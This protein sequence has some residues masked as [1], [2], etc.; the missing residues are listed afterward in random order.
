MNICIYYNPAVGVRTYLYVCAYVFMKVLRS[1]RPLL[2]R[3]TLYINLLKY[4]SHTCLIHACLFVCGERGAR[5]HL[6][7]NLAARDKTSTSTRIQQRCRYWRPGAGAVLSGS[8]RVD[9]IDR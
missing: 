2:P 7:A 1:L 9:A 6:F 3:L 4:F 8:Q 5:A